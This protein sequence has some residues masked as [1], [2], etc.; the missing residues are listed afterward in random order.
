MIFFEFFGFVREKFVSH[1]Q[2]FQNLR[3]TEFE[4]SNSFQQVIFVKRRHLIRVV[5]KRIREN[6]NQQPR[7]AFLTMRVTQTVDFTAVLAIY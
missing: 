3:Q 5:L 1:L 6:D 7:P 2:F 4:K